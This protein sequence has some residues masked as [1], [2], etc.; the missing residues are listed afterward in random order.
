MTCTLQAAHLYF[1]DFIANEKFSK[2]IFVYTH[3]KK[4]SQKLIE[5]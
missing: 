4:E 2:E 1:V 3:K 5:H